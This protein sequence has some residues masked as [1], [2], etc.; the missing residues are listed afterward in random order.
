MYTLVFSGTLG[1]SSAF[2][3]LSP[4]YLQDG[5]IVLDSIEYQVWRS[6]TNGVLINPQD[7]ANAQDSTDQLSTD[8]QI[9]SIPVCRKPGLM[10]F[11]NPAGLLG[12]YVNA[13]NE[14]CFIYP[15]VNA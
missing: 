13:Q 2:C 11:P 1:L 12:T 4:D 6:G 7:S 8:Q 3:A 9:V 15:A 14:T 10:G 5:T